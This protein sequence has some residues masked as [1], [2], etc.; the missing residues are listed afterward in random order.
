MTTRPDLN[1]RSLPPAAVALIYAAL[2]LAPL[3]LAALAAER[4]GPILRELGIGAGL[5]GLSLLLLQF[6]SSGR[7]E[8][9]SGRVGIDATMRLHQ[10]A[11]RSILA[12]ALLHPLAFV[13][14]GSPAEV[15]D[16]LRGLAAVPS[17]R[18][19]VVAL[20]V[21]IVL[22]IAAI[23][24]RRLPLRY[25][26]WRGSHALLALVA[27][28]GA[29]HHALTVG[30]YSSAGLLA[31][32]WGLLAAGAFAAF[33]YGYL[34]KPF[35]LA[36]RAYRVRSNESRGD[37]IRELVL[38]PVSGASLA[39]RAGQFVWVD[40]GRRPFTLR[41]HPFSL[42]SSPREGPDLRLLIKARGDFSSKLADILPGTQAFVDGPHGNFSCHGRDG[43]S[44]ALFAGGI[45]IAPI[46]GILRDLAAERDARPIGLVYGARNVGRLV[47]R[48]EIGAFGSVLDLQTEFV[49]EEPPAEWT[50]GRG[51]ITREAVKRA[52]RGRDPRRSLCLICGPTPM[53][54]AIERHLL[55]LGVPARQIVFERFEYD[56]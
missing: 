15:V 52:L 49:L 5:A 31:G 19:G 54:L 23:W 24:R 37:D 25:E 16:G 6:L 41:D 51:E 10:L 46:L 44:L 11:A 38:S 9:L 30:S 20:A 29:L 48:Q 4:A 17:M 33:G 42:A 1:R 28:I 39:Y 32:Y 26:R 2:V 36:R 14:P 53:M 55:A 50:G 18:S 13:L 34:V 27:S 35:R 47:A 8:R 22:V 43:D 21:L 56:E 45:G 12:L 40:F 7:F 3:A